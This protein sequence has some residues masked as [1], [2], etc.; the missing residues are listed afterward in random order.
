MHCHVLPDAVAIPVSER[1]MRAGHVIGVLGV[2]E[3]PLG[4][5]AVGLGEVG[6]RVVC[7]PVVHRDAGFGGD[8][9]AQDFLAGRLDDARAANG[10][11]GVDAE[12]FFE[13]WE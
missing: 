8:P 12:G 7:R 6:G 2:A 4:D 11:W 13:T 3:P 10:D 9:G 5:V 1:L